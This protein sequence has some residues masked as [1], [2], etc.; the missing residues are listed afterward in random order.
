MQLTLP[1]MVSSFGPLFNVYFIGSVLSC[2]NT[3]PFPHTQSRC[4]AA[5]T[6]NYHLE[7]VASYYCLCCFPIHYL[8]KQDIDKNYISGL[9]KLFYWESCWQQL[10]H[11]P[12]IMNPVRAVCKA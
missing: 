3:G 4:S 12:V 8:Y 6:T 2:F 1:S 5:H 11:L 9:E 10:Q 7:S